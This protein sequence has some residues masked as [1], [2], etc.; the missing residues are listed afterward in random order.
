MILR[1]VQRCRRNLQRLQTPALTAES[2]AGH[3]SRGSQ[4]RHAALRKALRS[5]GRPGRRQLQHQIRTSQE[6]HLRPGVLGK[7]REISPLDKIAAHADYNRRVL[8]QPGTQLRQLPAMAPVE[9]VVFRDHSRDS[10][11]TPPQSRSGKFS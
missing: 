6:R 7:N 11:G 8:P 3:Y 5:G 1:T 9:G 4:H 2:K 10:H